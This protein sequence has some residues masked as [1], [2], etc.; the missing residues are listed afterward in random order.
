MAGAQRR[1]GTRG[2]RES[3]RQ[4]G[5]RSARKRKKQRQQQK[6]GRGEPQ[7]L[8]EGDVQ[9]TNKYGRRGCGR[10][11]RLLLLREIELLMRNNCGGA[12]AGW[13]D[14]IWCGE[15]I[16]LNTKKEKE[17][18]FSAVPGCLQVPGAGRLGWGLRQPEPRPIC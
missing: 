17:V 3:A 9:N 11:R 6:K 8:P 1:S 5:K 14:E 16:V 10:R 7:R 13:G 4:S 18:L 15:K 12:G 2:G